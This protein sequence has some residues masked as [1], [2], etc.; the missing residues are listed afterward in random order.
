MTREVI[1][2]SADAT[3]G[4]V[5]TALTEHEC[6]HLPLVDGDTV[7]G[8]LSDRDLRRVEGLL[9]LEVGSIDGSEGIFAQPARALLS[10]ATVSVEEDAPI[11]DAI[12]RLVE[13]RI[14]TLVVTD[15]SGALVGMLSY[16]DVLAAARGRL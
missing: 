15:T 8:V 14:G 13:N 11:D 1:T 5:M 10:G 2:I 9:A 3:I 4:E 12:D 6:R 7:V 16:V